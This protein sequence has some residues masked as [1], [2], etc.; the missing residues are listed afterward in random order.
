MQIR[1]F[2][3]LI[4][5]TAL[6][7]FS[8]LSP[9]LLFSFRI[10]P[11]ISLPPFLPRISLP[12]FLPPISLCLLFPGFITFAIRFVTYYFSLQ[13]IFLFY[14]KQS[15]FIFRIIIDT[16]NA[17]E[18]EEEKIPTCSAEHLVD[19]N[20]S[21]RASTFSFASLV[22]NGSKFSMYNVGTQSELFADSLSN[23]KT[24]TPF[25]Q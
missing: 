14:L 18:A 25:G 22:T 23:L 3:Q 16:D 5:K 6:C 2:S 11:P 12:A 4:L 10:S 21:V 17:I 24:L 15:L 20:S 13:T 7:I 9:F 19:L 1:G 8:P